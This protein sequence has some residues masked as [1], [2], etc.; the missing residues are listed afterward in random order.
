ML[1]NML[2]TNKAGLDYLLWK[3]PFSNAGPDDLTNVSA[4]HANKVYTGSYTRASLAQLMP[5]APFRKA[6]ELS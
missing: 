1:V 6:C 4:R 3:A 5:A 2:D